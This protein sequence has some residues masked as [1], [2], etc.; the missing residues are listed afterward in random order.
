[1]DPEGFQGAQDRTV[2]C[3]YSVMDILLINIKW[4]LTLFDY[5]TILLDKV[6]FFKIVSCG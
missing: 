1:M 4:V 2:E 6:M 5:A 3:G